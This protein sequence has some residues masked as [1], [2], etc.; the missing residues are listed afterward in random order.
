MFSRRHF[1]GQRPWTT[2]MLGQTEGLPPQCPPDQMARIKRWEGTTPIW[3]CGP[4]EP[5]GTGAQAPPATEPAPARAPPPQAPAPPAPAAGPVSPMPPI[6]G[7]RPRTVTIELRRLPVVILRPVTFG[8]RPLQQTPA[9]PVP[10]PA[11]LPPLPV[12]EP[13]VTEGRS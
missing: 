10:E 2:P 7:T 9:A 11:P 13:P 12:E 1:M 8:P 4:K 3:E 5:A 6:T